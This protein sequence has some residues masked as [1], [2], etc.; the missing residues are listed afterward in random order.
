MLILI[1][2]LSQGKLGEEILFC[3]HGTLEGEVFCVCMCFTYFISFICLFVYLFWFLV[4]YWGTVSS[5]QLQRRSNRNFRLA[6]TVGAT[7]VLEGLPKQKNRCP[8][9]I[10]IT[11]AA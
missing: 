4:L 5:L 11:L 10:S 8:D 3:Y 9:L 6:V 1:V 7:S 2:L